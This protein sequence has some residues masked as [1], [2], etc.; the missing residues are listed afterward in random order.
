MNS[1]ICTRLCNRCSSCN[2]LLRILH[3]D[4]LFL[5]MKVNYSDKAGVTIKHVIYIHIYIYTI[6]WCCK[7]NYSFYNR[8]CYLF[9]QYR[10]K[11]RTKE[12]NCWSRYDFFRGRI[13]Y[14]SKHKLLSNFQTSTTN[15]EQL[16]KPHL[17]F[18]IVYVL[19]SQSVHVW[20]FAGY[21]VCFFR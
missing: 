2:E 16:C 15:W 6:Y 18:W 20:W 12:K 14:S 17:Y 21:V 9:R 8:W 11:R 3:I 5:W 10:F 13:N 7:K 19:A 1:Y 4:V